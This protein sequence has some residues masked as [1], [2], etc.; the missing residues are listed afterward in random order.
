VLSTGQKQLL[1]ASLL[2]YLALAGY[3]G[4]LH[5]KARKVPRAEQ[6]LHA[7]I[8]LSLVALC[9]GLFLDFARWVLP[10]LAAFVL[11][12]AVDELG[13]HAPLERRERRLHHAAYACFALF[14]AVAWQFGALRWPAA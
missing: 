11:A 4:W 14:A 6:A 1:L 2:P 3:D 10:A 7:A 8:A 9:A 12:A 5:E 13:F